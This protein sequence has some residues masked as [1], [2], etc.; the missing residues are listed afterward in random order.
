MDE[1]MNTLRGL[2]KGQGT[3]ASD[4]TILKVSGVS[5]AFVGVQALDDVTFSVTAGHIKA[6][7]GPNGAGKTTILN[8]INGLLKPNRGSVSFRGHELIGRKVHSTAL[9]GISRTFQLI[10]LFTV[11]EATVL[12][13]VM[14]GGHRHFQPAINDVLFFRLRTAR[15]E[16]E[17]REKAMELLR[18][19]GMDWAAN[20]TPGS[21][22]FGNQRMVELARALMADPELLLLD[23]PASGLN[24]AEV[25]H[26]ME[27]LS[28]IRSRG[29]TILL[30]EHNMKLVMNVSNDI[31][32]LD[33]GRWLAEGKPTAICNNPKVV[34]AYLGTECIDMGGGQ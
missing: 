16:K 14:V 21:L 29:V 3:T 32:V 23:E 26:F 10:R 8:V 5:K 11:N 28:M 25:E 15:K 33:F 2:E 13:N 17:L 4:E 19:V 9:L 1:I 20:M 7:I 22:S 18:F 12:D 27:L 31:V 6:L 34:E 30:V 24:E